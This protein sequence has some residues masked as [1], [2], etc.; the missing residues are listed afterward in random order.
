MNNNVE[1]CPHCGTKKNSSLD[2]RC[3]YC[4]YQFLDA[5]AK[6]NMIK[7][8]GKIVNIVVIGFCL[9]FLFFGLIF[10]GVGLYS[11]INEH[12]KTE[13]FEK[14]IGYF[15]DFDY[16]NCSLDEDRNLC[17]GIYS[18]EVDGK[19]YEVSPQE[20]SDDFEQQ[21]NVYY[22]PDNPE[23]GV[24]YVNWFWLIFVGGIVVCFCISIF[25]VQ[26]VLFMKTLKKYK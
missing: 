23:E 2:I 11:T 9:P 3:H 7:R 26:K 20:L 22:N 25:I 6:K 5:V 21:R 4:G 12:N 8:A 13:G 19:T 14:T 1:L 24:I 17:R 16:E 15:V 18:Y 10:L